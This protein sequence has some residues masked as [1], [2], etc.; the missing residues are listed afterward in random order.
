MIRASLALALALL[1]TPARAGWS[2]AWA[3]E[4]NLERLD[5]AAIGGARASVDMA[6][7]ILTDVPVIEALATAA[8][9]GVAVRVYRDNGEAGRTPSPRVAAALDRLAR[10]PG[11]QVRVKAGAALMHLKSYCIDR[12]LLRGGAANFSASGLKAQDNDRWTTDDPTAVAGF[13]ATFDAMWGR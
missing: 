8:E 12:A 2:V 3:P 1:A 7:Y 4:T 11:V 6:A 5:V 9:R 13:E 10:A